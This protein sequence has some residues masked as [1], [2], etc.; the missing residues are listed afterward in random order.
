MKR[1]TK[2]AALL[3]PALISPAYAAEQ[4][5][6]D[7]GVLMSRP[8]EINNN[9]EVVG[10][11]YRY[12]EITGIQQIAEAAGGDIQSSELTGLNDNGT[13][14]GYRQKRT[15]PGTLCPYQRIPFGASISAP[16]AILN[17]GTVIGSC[18]TICSRPVLSF[19]DSFA[20]RASGNNVDFFQFSEREIPPH[21]GA[22]GVN[23]A[24]QVVG[25]AL[26]K[27]SGVH[28]ERAFLFDA[29][30]GGMRDLGALGGLSSRATAIN[31]SGVIVGRA[32]IDTGA[33]PV[34]HAFI[35]DSS[36][37]MRD[38]GSLGGSSFAAAI[39]SSGTI[40]GDSTLADRT[41][42]R[43]IIYHPSFGLK[44]L[45]EFLPANSGW[46]L[47]AATDI[48]DLG[49]IVGSGFKDGALHGFLLTSRDI[50]T[51]D[52]RV[53]DIRASLKA[54]GKCQKELKKKKSI[55]KNSKCTLEVALQSVNGA[56]VGSRQ[57]HIERSSKS[58][59]PWTKLAEGTTG[60]DG[61]GK[62]SLRIK[63]G[64]YLR[65]FVPKVVFGGDYSKNLKFRVR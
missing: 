51:S 32:D 8:V 58:G 41:K 39:N 4:R 2:R 19:R 64:G 10:G 16:E 46:E 52:P 55:A 56:E 21:D 61:K 42:L 34:S 65:V 35:Y 44:N 63:K 48:N 13:I 45:N 7:L 54:T 49:E 38:L 40:V 6:V 28:V 37:G 31:N 47:R 24:G 33:F 17:D 53:E 50:P 3:L 60:S 23:S 57:F 27:V 43:A 11:L 59:G 26:K 22:L 62:K 30:G 12:S 14:I 20:C 29:R 1:F 15:A 18:E 36:G 9:G 25:Y 5:I